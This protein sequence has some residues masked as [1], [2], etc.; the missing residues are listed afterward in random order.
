M[1]VVWLG[2]GVWCQ[3]ARVTAGADRVV[4]GMAEPTSWAA[5]RVEPKQGRGR[6]NRD[7]QVSAWRSEG[8]NVSFYLPCFLSYY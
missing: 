8:I 6:K 7:G 1:M 4:G 2:N 3:V 5:V